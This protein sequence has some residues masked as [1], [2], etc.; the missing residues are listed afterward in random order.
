M[1]STST[2]TIEL[3]Q[4]ESEQVEKIAPVP[5]TKPTDFV[6]KVSGAIPV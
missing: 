6:I 4:G 2:K 3:P 5:D 1:A